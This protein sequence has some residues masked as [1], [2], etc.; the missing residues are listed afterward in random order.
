MSS[1]WGEKIRGSLCNSGSRN[2]VCLIV[3]GS[4][5]KHFP[6]VRDRSDEPSLPNLSQSLKRKTHFCGGM[7]SGRS[8]LVRVTRGGSGIAPEGGLPSSDPPLPQ[9]PPSPFF[10]FS[11]PNPV[12]IPPPPTLFPASSALIRCPWVGKG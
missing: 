11:H 2:K 9:L 5:P 12:P 10:L 1:G 7:L 6:R 3:M 8:Y 4:G